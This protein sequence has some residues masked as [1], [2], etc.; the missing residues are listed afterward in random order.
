MFEDIKP[1]KI[2]SSDGKKVFFT[3]DCHY[4]HRNI[5]EF[6]NRPFKDV[7]EMQAILIENWNS[8]VR[9]QDIVFDLGDFAFAP[10]WKWIEILGQLNGRHHLILGNH[11]IS[12]FPGDT[13]MRLFDGVYNKL[14]IKIDDR[15][16]L[17]NHEPLLCY[18]GTYRDKAGLVYQLFGH[19]HS[20]PLSN[21]GKDDPRLEFL[22][23]TQYDVGVDN[24]NFTPI[25]FEEVDSI[26][27][28]KLL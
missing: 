25:S 9:P 3:S 10:N 20:G 14:I 15:T 17:L 23:P 11:D 1:I 5:L 21:K 19:V 2:K 8:V 7:D 24:N 18:G 28:N 27:Q 22:F 26:I 4:N 13:V 16:I 6:C 12:R